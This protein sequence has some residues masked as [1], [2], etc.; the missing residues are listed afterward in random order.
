MEAMLDKSAREISYWINQKHINNGF[1][2]ETVSALTRVGFDIEKLS[3]LEI[4]CDPECSK[5]KYSTKT[6]LQ[7]GSDFKK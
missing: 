2:F 3:R 5:P 6:L 4:H 1:A 7:T